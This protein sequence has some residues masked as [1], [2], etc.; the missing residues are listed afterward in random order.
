MFKPVDKKLDLTAFEHEML[1][2]W[3]ETKAFEK[4]RE[5]TEGGPKWSS[6]RRPAGRSRAAP[7]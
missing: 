6:L 7:R 5:Q 4:L 2:F 3:E 1:G